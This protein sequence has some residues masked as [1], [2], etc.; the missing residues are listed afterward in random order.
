MGEGKTRLALEVASRTAG[1]YRSGV[2]FCDL[3]AVTLPHAVIRAVATAAGLSERAFVRLDDQLVD[4]LAGQQVLL[5]LDNC[6]HV[7]GAVADLAGRLLRQT[8]AVSLLATS[9]ERLGVD[10]EHVWPVRPLAIRGPGAPA[11]R[12]FLDRARAADPAATLQSSGAAVETLCASLDGLPLAIELAAARLPGTTVPELSRNLRDRFPLLT[13]GRRADSRH[14]SLRA[15]VDWSYDQLAPAQQALLRRLSV[16]QASFDA[17]AAGAVAAGIGAAGDS[18]SA[19]LH[20]VDC[21][22]VSAEPDELH[23]Y[24]LWRCQSEVFRW[25]DVSTAAAA[26]SRSPYYP[27]ALA[28]AAFGAIYRGDMHGGG[29]AA[30]AALDAARGLDPV[31]ARRP[32]EALGDL[33]IFRGE[34]RDASDLYQRAYDLS[35]GNGEFL[36]AAWDAASAA[37]AFA[38][39][40]SPEEASRLAGQAH[41]AADRSGSPSAQAFASWVSGEIA[42][43]TSPGQAQHHLQRA[44]AL[45]A[46]AGSRFVDGIS[47]VSLATL[48]AQHGDPAVALRH[49][50]QVILQWQQ[51]GAWTPLWVTIRTLVDL[52]ARV[53]ASRDAATL[54]GAVAS[55]SSGAPPYGADADR[56]RSSAARLRDQLGSGFGVCVDQGRQLD[57]TQV[58]GL[59][60]GAIRRAAGR[61]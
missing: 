57:G 23:W 28:S 29:A 42:A 10:G 43:G 53:G 39:G 41:A 56:L 15:V 44:V 6:E 54:Y 30:R 61:G 22:L 16:F 25:A 58:I 40:D 45:A 38:Y 52:L 8:R 24:A 31:T 13:V 9:R 60:L 46:T 55:A 26:R 37:A 21:S 47:R 3:A 12:L 33:A 2:V 59:A 1:S 35:T 51:A 5:I 50:E 11:V 34:L 48:H 17:S 49:Y 14:H 36:D 18:T 4:H 27:D 7:A 20:L 19:L 32:L